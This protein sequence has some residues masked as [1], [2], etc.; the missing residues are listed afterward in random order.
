[1]Q[2]SITRN[3]WETL[4][5]CWGLVEFCNSFFLTFLA[6]RLE[7]QFSNFMAKISS[8]IRQKSILESII[9]SKKKT[10]MRNLRTCQVAPPFALTF[11]LLESS[12][13]YTHTSLLKHVK[14]CKQYRC[15]SIDFSTMIAIICSITSYHVKSLWCKV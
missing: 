3:K 9:K 11:R 4:S 8:K 14:K 2:Y 5:W 1:M 10:W 7:R 15:V 12:T 6:A 13:V